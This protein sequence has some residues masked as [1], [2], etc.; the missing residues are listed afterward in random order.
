VKTDA[1]GNLTITDAAL[2][3]NGSGG[4]VYAGPST[5]DATYSTVAWIAE[6][7]VDKASHISRGLVLY[8]SGVKIGALVGV[9]GG[10]MN[11]EFTT[12]GYV[13]ITGQTGVVRADGGFAVSG[14]AGATGSF[15][16]SNGKTVTVT[17]GIVTSI[18]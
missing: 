6:G 1:S 12:G 16:S 8:S 17:K 14:S 13:L 9:A 15:T 18:V 5:F 10:Y 2:T 3:I 11:M 4:K 7:G